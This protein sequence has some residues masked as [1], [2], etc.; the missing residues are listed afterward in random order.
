MNVVMSDSEV[1]CQL[2]IPDEAD[3]E[4]AIEQEVICFKCTGSK[5]NK[6]GLPCR[7]CKATGVIMSNELS[8]ITKLV[9]AEVGEY[10][11]EKFTEMFKTYLVNKKSEQDAQVHTSIECDGC[12]VNPIKG[13]RYQSTFYNDYD[14]CEVCEK[15]GIHKEHPLI[16]IRRPGQAPFK[17]ITQMTSNQTFHAQQK[18]SNPNGQQP[19]K[20]NRQ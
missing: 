4:E 19:T 9:K 13:I 15:K 11:R 18:T 2:L 12:G 6:K 3:N 20:P 16:K 10:C 8:E 14:I 1:N 7:K 5:V 17:V